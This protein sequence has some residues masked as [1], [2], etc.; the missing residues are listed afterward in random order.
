MTLELSKLGIPESSKLVLLV[1]SLLISDWQKFLKEAFSLLTNESILSSN[2][3]RQAAA[4]SSRLRDADILTGKS[5]FNFAKQTCK[6]HKKFQKQFKTFI[7]PDFSLLHSRTFFSKWRCDE[8]A[9]RF[10]SQQLIAGVG[11]T[12]GQY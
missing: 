4:L 6:N 12:F 1:L 8:R 10:G 2:L 7:L 3:A 5:Q 11:G 9:D